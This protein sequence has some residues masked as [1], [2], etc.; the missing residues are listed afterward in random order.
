M[1]LL[2]IV[3]NASQGRK[4]RKRQRSECPPAEGL[5]VYP[6]LDD[7]GLVD[8]RYLRVEIGTSAFGLL[9]RK[10]TAISVRTVGDC[11]SRPLGTPSQ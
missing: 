5:V 11:R 10:R 1:G 3:L 2:Q 8:L 7:W 4:A 9:L 6:G